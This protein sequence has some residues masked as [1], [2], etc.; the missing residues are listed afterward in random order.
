M[1]H[2]KDLTGQWFNRWH[3]IERAENDK[4]GQAQWHCRCICGNESVVAGKDLRQGKSKS[5]GCYHIDT[6]SITSRKHGKS[7]TRLYRIW[8]VMRRRCSDHLTSHFYLYG[9]R[10]ITVCDEWDKS[11]ESFYLWAINNGY[12]DGLSIDRIDVN[13][14]Y[15]PSNCRWATAKQQARNKRNNRLVEYNGEKKTLIEW[16]EILGFNYLMVK[17]RLQ[18]GNWTV[19]EAFTTPKLKS[20]FARQ[21]AKEAVG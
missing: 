12:S 9:G 8:N 5:C 20:K 11:F 19:K 18:K 1:S 3:V 7:Q 21:K 14:N 6:I 13:G 2:L 15:D 10:G 4:R 16:S 17:G